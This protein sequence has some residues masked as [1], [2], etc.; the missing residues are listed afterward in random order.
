[1]K[2]II[3]AVL[4]T[5]ILNGCQSNLNSDIKAEALKYKIEKQN[6]S[7]GEPGGSMEYR[8]ML[9]VDSLPSDQQIKNTATFL[10]KDGNEKR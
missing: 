3:N 4:I 6:G 8:V 1:M 9:D 5:L 7:F 2:D 10:W